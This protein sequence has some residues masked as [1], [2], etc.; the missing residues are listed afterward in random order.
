M[1]E[2]KDKKPGVIKLNDKTI[3]KL[4]GLLQTRNRVNAQMMELLEVYQD[5][6]GI[7]GEWGLNVQTWELSKVEAP[8]E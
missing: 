6:L 8:T 2:K 5:A 7:E 4:T 3:S 1:A